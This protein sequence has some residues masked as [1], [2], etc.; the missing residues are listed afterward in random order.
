MRH[1]VIYSLACFLLLACVKP[2][3]FSVPDFSTLEFTGIAY[4]GKLPIPLQGVL[5][6]KEGLLKYVIA[7]RQGVVLGYGSINPATG[8]NKIEFSQSSG[9][10]KLLEITADALIE[11]MRDLDDPERK[12]TRWKIE[13]KKM[14]FKSS[15]LELNAY[16]DGLE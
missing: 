8:L 2:S 10:K 1:I 7:A 16:M 13:N 4:S 15:H 14:I 6:Q 9:T 12:D 3:P 5:I 11:L